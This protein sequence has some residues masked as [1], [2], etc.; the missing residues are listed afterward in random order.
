MKGLRGSLWC[1]WAFGALALVGCMDMNAVTVDGGLGSGIS[2][3]DAA[4]GI[5]ACERD[6]YPDSS[7]PSL[8][9]KAVQ[10]CADTPRCPETIRCMFDKGCFLLGVSEDINR[11]SLPCVLGAGITTPSD[12]AVV[13]A[14]DLS[15]C[16][17][18]SYPDACFPDDAGAL[19]T[20]TP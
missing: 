11:C 16:A 19:L 2:D 9:A 10:V 14:V 6:L 18:R 17:D 8:C 15:G 12:P 1:G 5:S 20:R 3:T 7:T 13:N 4:H